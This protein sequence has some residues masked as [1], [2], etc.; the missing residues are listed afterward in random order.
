[1]NISQEQFEAV[2]NFAIKANIATVITSLNTPVSTF[3]SSLISKLND[4]EYIKHDLNLHPLLMEKLSTERFITFT[5]ADYRAEENVFYTHGEKLYP[6]EEQ[7]EIIKRDN[8]GALKEGYRCLKFLTKEQYDTNFSIKK[9]QNDYDHFVAEWKRLL[10]MY[11]TYI[12][13]E[14]FKQLAQKYGVADLISAWDTPVFPPI[15]PQ[16]T[17]SR[18]KFSG[19]VYPTYFS[20]IATKGCEVSYADYDEQLEKLV[21]HGN[22]FSLTEQQLADLKAD[23]FALVFDENGYTFISNKAQ[24]ALMVE[25]V[26]ENKRYREFS[27]AYDQTQTRI[28]IEK[29]GDECKLQHDVLAALPF[30]YY[31][32]IKVNIRLLQPTG[33]LTGARKNTVDHIVVEEAFSKGRLKRK[34]NEFLCGGNSSYGLTSRKNDGHTIHTRHGELPYKVT[35]DR[36][37]EIAHRLLK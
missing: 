17:K 20:E 26:E 6:S 18:L 1:M 24:T 29:Y 11:E 37:L 33:N 35:C 4:G 15:K 36:C 25:A 2:K 8:F 27:K 31:V 16:N 30:P 19:E 13:Y 28:N 10:P 5:M 14:D 21:I 7:L 12:G 32:A 9:A 22:K 3:D 23:N 34:E